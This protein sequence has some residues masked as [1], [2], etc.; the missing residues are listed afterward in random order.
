MGGGG[1]GPSVAADY[2][3][4]LGV[5]P[6]CS[7]AEIKKA[8]HRAA[9]QCHPDQAD[10]RYESTKAASSLWFRTV[11]EAYDVLS[12]PAQRLRGALTGPSD[13]FSCSEER[14]DRFW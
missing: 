3:E 14:Q 5:K 4:I 7:A 2:Y 11:K 6:D 1:G 10:Q 8:Y 12:N 9:K 13:D